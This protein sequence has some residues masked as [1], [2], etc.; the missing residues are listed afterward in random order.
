MKP[1]TGTPEFVAWTLV[2]ACELR[3]HYELDDP[4]A[5]E[6]RL[7]GVRALAAAIAQ[8]RVVDQWC[9]ASQTRDEPDAVPLGFLEQDVV[10]RWGDRQKV[11]AI[12]QNCPANVP[13]DPASRIPNTVN[14]AGCYGWL[15]LR[16]SNR[17]LPQKLAGPNSTP[18]QAHIAWRA[19][20]HASSYRGKAAQ[21]LAEQ[22]ELALDPQDH[23]REDDPGLDDPWRLVA[24]LR[25]AAQPGDLQVVAKLLPAGERSGRVWILPAHCQHCG[26][27][28]TTGR[29]PCT[30]CGSREPQIPARKRGSRG[31]RPYRDLREVLTS[32]QIVN[33][34]QAAR[35]QNT[36]NQGSHQ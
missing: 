8:Q 29:P 30:T 2:K 32:E 4:F 7:K 34:R 36:L 31:I 13:V 18:L 14:W 25:R 16:D 35:L 9:L 10:R 15:A 19:L 6:R 11:S 33:L 27:V 28:S 20:W 5:T 17:D 3:G 24:A 23:G 12:C 26:A 1:M 22:L 21:Q